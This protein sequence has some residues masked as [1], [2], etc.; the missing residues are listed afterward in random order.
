MS[1]LSP[2]ERQR[3]SRSN[4]DDPTVR[5][6]KALSYVLRHG[7]KKEGISMRTDGYV[8]L[9]ELLSLP[10]FT[11]TT[12]EEI[13]TVV[14]TNDKQRYSLVSEVDET[15]GAATWWIRA[16]QGHTLNGRA[17][18]FLRVVHSYAEPGGFI[19]T[20]G[21]AGSFLRGPDTEYIYTLAAVI[22]CNMVAE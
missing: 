10:R 13:E 21:Q 18:S 14:K 2:N 7:A 3:R 22:E 16:N 19:L 11:K 15:T 17:G 8:L 4:N 1:T 9:N 5:L 12:F 20:Q 6:S